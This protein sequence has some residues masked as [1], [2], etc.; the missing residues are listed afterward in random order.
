M[1]WNICTPHNAERRKQTDT[2]TRTHTHTTFTVGTIKV[3]AQCNQQQRQARHVRT[4]LQ[5]N[6]FN[7]STKQRIHW[8]GQHANQHNIKVYETSNA[9]VPTVHGRISSTVPTI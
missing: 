2:H 3:Q 5:P 4:C 6:A 1:A 9:T 8:R 7:S